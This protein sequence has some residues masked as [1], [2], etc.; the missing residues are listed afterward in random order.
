LY[1]VTVTT[2]AAPLNFRRFASFTSSST[3]QRRRNRDTRHQLPGP[4]SNF[5]LLFFPIF[6]PFQ[7]PPPANLPHDTLQIVRF[8]SPPAEDGL[9][10]QDSPAAPE[11]GSEQK[12]NY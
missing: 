9:S 10:R 2:D 11:D 4:E 3:C 12:H 1:N 7:D 8:H 5:P 6:F